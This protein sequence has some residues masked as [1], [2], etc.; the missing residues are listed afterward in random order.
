MQPCIIHNRQTQAG[1]RAWV[2]TLIYILDYRANEVTHVN[3]MQKLIFKSKYK[4]QLQFA[5]FN[6]RFQQNYDMNKY[7]ARACELYHLSK[8]RIKNFKLV[9][10]ISKYIEFITK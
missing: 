7:N 10:C 2:D 8:P 5:S 6:D 1:G 9:L 3:Q 4:M